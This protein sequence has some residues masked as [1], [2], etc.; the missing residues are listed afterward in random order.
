VKQKR[1][2]LKQIEAILKQAEVGVPRAAQPRR[3]GVSPSWP[4]GIPCQKSHS[5]FPDK[6]CNNLLHELLIRVGFGKDWY[7]SRFLGRK[8]RISGNAL[9]WSSDSRSIALA[10]SPSSS[11]KSTGHIRSFD[12]A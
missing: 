1:F 12:A 5:R 10:S 7:L 11:V 4:Y 2:T 9:L 3:C 6:L 8:P